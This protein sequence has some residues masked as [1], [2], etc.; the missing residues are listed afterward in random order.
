MEKLG[1]SQRY[2]VSKDIL[3][4]MNRLE[5]IYTLLCCSLTVPSLTDIYYIFAR[6]ELEGVKNFNLSSCC[7]RSVKVSRT[8]PKTGFI[9]CLI[10][11]DDSV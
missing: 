1:M 5:V 4:S 11:F 8:T 10:P 3:V 9:I 7:L 6:F 2:S